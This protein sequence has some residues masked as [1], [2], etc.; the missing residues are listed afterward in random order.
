LLVPGGV[1]G[2][3]LS[4]ASGKGGTGKTLIATNIAASLKHVGLVDCDVEEPN[5]YLFFPRP[6]LNNV[7]D[8]Q[9]PIPIVNENKCTRCGKCSEFC[10][11]NALA[12][13]PSEVLLF[14]ELCHGCGGCLLVCPE[15]AISE[16]YR[17]IG[18][19]YRGNSGQIDLL[20]G[21]L[22]P[23]EPIATPLIRALKRI[24][25]GDMVLVDCPPGA[26][27]PMI[28]S[29]KGS[30]F[31]LLVTEPT[32]FGLYDLDIA[33]KVIDTMK[34][35]CGVLINKSSLGER[36]VYDYCGKKDLPILM[37]IPLDRKIA[38]IYSRGTLLVDKMPEWNE[39]FRDLAGRI[40]E[41][42]D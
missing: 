5:D 40:K 39:P 36:D 7:Q 8:C 21:E 29:V 2:V 38:E 15:G 31:C 1:I 11:Y 28:E 19:I 22:N 37:E 12:V 27:C 42:I 35:P 10:A 30:D 17:S 32:P 4:I 33:V 13:F 25:D 23:S 6:K 24:A 41:M 9:M 16:G 14:S 26:A 20:W 34:I 18:K 3:M